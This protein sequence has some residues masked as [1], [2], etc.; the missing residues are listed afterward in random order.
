MKKMKKMKFLTSWIITLVI[1]T[2][3]SC[4]NDD[5]SNVISQFHPNG[6][7]ILTAST[8]NVTASTYKFGDNPLKTVNSLDI[9]EINNVNHIILNADELLAVSVDDDFTPNGESVIFVLN[10]TDVYE[11]VNFGVSEDGEAIVLTGQVTNVTNDTK[12]L[13]ITLQESQFGAGNSEYTIQ[14]D[15]AFL[16]GTLGTYT[17][18]Q[19]I[20]INTNNPDVKTIVLGIIEGSLNDEVNVETGRLIREAG[21]ATHLKSDSEIYSGGVDLFC[22][23][24]TR[25]REVGA[26]IGVHSWC[27]YEGLTADQL[28]QSSPGHDS[29]LAY[30]RDVLGDVNGPN[31]YFFTINAA[32]FDG[33]HNM[34]NTEINQYQLLTN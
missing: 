28:P 8:I 14:G 7:K 13:V 1:I 17:Y 12:N 26:I 11:G 23:G 5:N 31:F 6:I 2:T 24:I 18:N 9:E 32:P 33:I 27:C 3:I 15:Q 16:S 30:F 10:E 34:T 22:S 25:S 29:Q 4:K 19:I 21:Y 20:N